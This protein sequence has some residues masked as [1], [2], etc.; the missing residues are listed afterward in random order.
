MVVGNVDFESMTLPSSVERVDI[1]AGLPAAVTRLCQRLADLG[2]AKLPNL[3][4]VSITAAQCA[5]VDIS[6]LVAFASTLK[7]LAVAPGTRPISYQPTPIALGAATSPSVERWTAQV[8]ATLAQLVGLETA[9]V[10]EDEVQHPRGN[11]PY[12]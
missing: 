7:C 12:S 10:H 3:R 9:R 6:P 11:S 4:E 5:E 2:A 1:S 8:E